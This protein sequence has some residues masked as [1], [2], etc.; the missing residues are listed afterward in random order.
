MIQQNQAI[1]GNKVIT[2]SERNSIRRIQTSKCVYD[3]KIKGAYYAKFSF[4]R[5]CAF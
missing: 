3:L 2:E 5:E 4:F 1:A